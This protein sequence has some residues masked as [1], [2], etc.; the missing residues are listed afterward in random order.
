MS[1][2]ILDVRDLTVD[3]SSFGETTKIVRGVSF[4]IHEGETVGIV[5]ESGCGKS[6]TAMAIMRLIQCPP[7]VLGGS[8]RLH[9]REILSLSE[10][11]M[12]QVRGNEI[13]MI[14]QE[15][16]TS[17]NPVITVGKQLMEVFQTHQKLSREEAWKKSVEALKLVK[18]ALPEQRMKEYPYQLSGGMRQRVMI[19]MALSCRPRLLIADEPTTAL[20][21]T[22]Q[23]QILGLMRGLREELGTSIMLI[24]HDL[25]VVREVCSRAIIFY[26]GQIV[27]EGKVEELF[28]RPLHPYTQGLLKSIPALDD[29]GEKLYVIPGSVPSLQSLPG[30]CVFHPRCEYASEKC[31]QADP[32][33]FE[34]GGG[35]CARCWLYE[36]E[37]QA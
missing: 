2:R 33:M 11:E 37:G 36:K 25:G 32:P 27:E 9:D 23:A 28:Q 1:K 8:I 15:P 10:K 34:T 18:I 30:G 16:M 13:S 24:T 29:S 19:A 14:F 31:R 22:I 21:V 5:G 7:G 4:H 17:L 26:C 20:D 3:F 35:H 6:M 12:R